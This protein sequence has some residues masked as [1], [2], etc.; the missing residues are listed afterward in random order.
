[1]SE[2]P[3]LYDTGVL[4]D[5]YHGRDRVRPYFEQVLA[6]DAD[7]LLSAITE[8]ELR[9][10]LRPGEI[11]AHEALLSRFTI[12]PL[13]SAAARLAGQWRQVYEREGVGWMDAMIVATAVVSDATVLTRDRRLAAV[14]GDAAVFELYG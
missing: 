10:G 14:L 7:I 12:L 2:H 3:L 6:G 8:A 1:M 5:I 11:A 4:L 9:R 13:D